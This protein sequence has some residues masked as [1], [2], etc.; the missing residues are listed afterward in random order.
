MYKQFNNSIIPL[1]LQYV[2]TKSSQFSGEN[3][4]KPQKTV[5]GGMASSAPTV[6]Q[7][8][9]YSVKDRKVRSKIYCSVLGASLRLCTMPYQRQF[10][11]LL[12]SSSLNLVTPAPL[13]SALK[14]LYIVL[15]AE[16]AGKT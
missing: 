11:W 15:P 5:G 6:R 10:V 2:F 12:R 13:I 16:L 4:P 8:G 1:F 7:E 14:T 9:G 3:G